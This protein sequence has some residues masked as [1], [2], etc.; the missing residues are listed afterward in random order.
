M[1]IEHG[2][3]C[4]Q[5]YDQCLHKYLCQKKKRTAHRKPLFWLRNYGYASNDTIHSREEIQNPT[6]AT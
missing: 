3:I 6:A 1:V 4:H 2:Q 5:I